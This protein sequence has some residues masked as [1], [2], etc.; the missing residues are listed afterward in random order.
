MANRHDVIIWDADV[1]GTPHDFDEEMLQQAR[2]LARQ[3]AKSSAKLLAFAREVESYSQ[4]NDLDPIVKRYLQDFEKKVITA[5]TAAYC[6]ELPEYQW[7]SLLKVLIEA[8]QTHG[9]V[10]CDEELILLLLPD[11]SILPPHTARSWQDT[12]EELENDSGFPQTLKD[13][14]QLMITKIG[15]LLSEHSFVLNEDNT[16]KD[17]HISLRYIRKN[18]SVRHDLSF[19]CDGGDGEFILNVYLTI[20]ESNMAK[21]CSQS[22]FQYSMDGGGGVIKH[23]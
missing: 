7:R 18:A 9:L 16:D 20:D 3:G 14:H 2:V 17:S 10:L 13:F 21:I 6:I 5:N 19:Y 22:D 11:G 15:E 4:N 23:T 8:A 12:L 1:Y